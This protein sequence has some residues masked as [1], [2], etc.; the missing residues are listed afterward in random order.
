MFKLA[1]LRDTITIKPNLFGIPH[2]Q[3][4][5][6]EIN[7]KLANKVVIDVGLCICVHSIINIGDSY[8]FQGD[9]STYTKVQ[10]N[11]VVFR[12]A[13]GDILVAKLRSCSREGVYLTLGFFDNIFISA[14]SLMKPSRFDEKEQMWSW[15]YEDR[16]TGEITLLPME[17]GKM[18]RFKITEERFTDTSP[19]GPSAAT[20]TAS[21]ASGN[22]ASPYEIR[23]QM[24][25]YGL[26]ME[27]WWG[28]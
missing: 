5:K 27:S 3:V 11:M 25:E 19:V 26:G 23:G 20:V 13:V 10:Y 28:S 24:K 14:E 22:G 17:V 1:E 16:E 7:R 2:R 8:V 15:E 21:A 12:P 9:G 6:E 4:I 18:C